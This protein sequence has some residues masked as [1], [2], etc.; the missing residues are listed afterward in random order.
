AEEEEM[1]VE[2]RG[3]RVAAGGEPRE[4][5]LEL[6]M[7]R[8]GIEVATAVLRANA[9]L[10]VRREPDVRTIDLLLDGDLAVEELLDLGVVQELVVAGPARAEPREMRR[11]REAEEIA[12]V[13]IFSSYFS[14]MS[15]AQTNRTRTP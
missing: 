2:R 12:H 11:V 7:T 14:R 1:G 10:V 15:R 3:E 6:R 9:P 4:E 8:L 5:L 13:P